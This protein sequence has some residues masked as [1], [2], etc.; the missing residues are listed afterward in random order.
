MPPMKPFRVGKQTGPKDKN[1]G[2]RQS[3]SREDSFINDNDGP[4]GSD[5]NSKRHPSHLKGRDIGIWYARQA[6]RREDEELLNAKKKGDGPKLKPPPY[7]KGRDLDLWHKEQ[8]RIWQKAQKKEKQ[9]ESGKCFIKLRIEGIGHVEMK[10]SEL[11]AELPLLEENNKLNYSKSSNSKIESMNNKRN[12]NVSS[13]NDDNDI[14]ENAE[15]IMDRYKKLEDS[16]FKRKFLDNITGSIEDN[17]AASVQSNS[18]LQNVEMRN[19]ALKNELEAKRKNPKYRSMCEIRKKLPSYSKREEILDLLKNNQ[20]I[21]ISGETG[22]GKTTQMAQFILD[23]AIM[24]G[25][26]S[27]CRIVCT[28]PRRISAISV[29]ERVADERAER[30]GEGSVGY[31]IRLERRL[32]RDYGSILFCTTGILLQQI[33]QDSALN[34]YSHVIIDEIHERDTIS[35]FTLTILKSIIPVRPDIKVILMSATLNASA[36]S[37]YYN[38]CPSLNIPGFT[39]PVEELYLEDI[40]SLSGFRYFP[41]KLPQ[42]IRKVRPGDPFGEFVIPYVNEMRRSKKYP[43]SILNWLETP[44]SEDTDYELIGE[45]I[46]YICNNKE[47]GAILVF[48]SGWD[49]ISKLTRILRDKG[50]GN[51][52]RYIMIPLHSMLP[53]VSQKSVFDPPPRG[54]RKIILSTNIAETSVTIDDVVYVINNGRMKLKGYEAENNICTLKEEWVSLANARQRR[55]RAGRVRSGTCYHLYTRGRERSFDDYVLPEMMRTSLEEVILQAKILQVGM[56][57]PFLEKVMNPPDSKSLEVSL[58]LLT[59]LNAL[60]E[61]ENLTPLGFH[62]AKLPIGPLEGKM[63]ILGV[64]FS[65]LSPIMT[66]AASLNFKD[67]FFCPVNKEQQCREIRK[68]M[69]EGHQSD[70]L[71]VTRAMSKFLQAKQSNRGW[72]FCRE[73]FLMFNTMNMLHELKSQYARYLCD[74]GFIKSTNYA[75]HEYNMNS[76]NVKLL[77]CVLVAGLCPNIA[78]SQSKVKTSGRKLSKFVTAEDGKVDVHPKSVNAGDCYFES[79]LLLYHTK[80]KT[81]SIFLHDTTM[82]YPFPLVLFANSLKVTGEKTDH[83]TFSLNSQ[84][85]FTT[86]ARTANFIKTVRSRLKWLIDYLM[87]HPEDISFDSKSISGKALKLVVDLVSAEDHPGV[88]DFSHLF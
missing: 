11:D 33:Q 49:Q 68:E 38:E 4:S 57:T 22:C 80:L 47:D 6:S 79:P 61:K 40:Y 25:H 10:T 35:D 55:G 16:T 14:D 53:T 28:Q 52:S 48:L 50:F 24:S 36:F 77:K 42:R 7:L 29:A 18:K 69:D 62:L 84:I 51:T 54:V 19:A 17:L 46:N 70:H 45:L 44:M 86:S 12:L 58:K 88:L 74:L 34:Y 82:V 32:S 59:D 21:L 8:N 30:V 64:M 71:M 41:K 73:N 65:C 60:D 20:V 76:N 72:D 66:I 81:S 9:K 27:T 1:R 39:F 2:P 26:G 23:D 13:L 37:S 31:Q 85:H 83:V 87:S 78:V 56:V 67:P 3:K 63:I 75:D 43:A 5:I 15:Y